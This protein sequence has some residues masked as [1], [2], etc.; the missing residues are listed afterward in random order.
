MTKPENH[1]IFLT[2]RVG[3]QLAK[4]VL[5][6]M[7][8]EGYQPHSSHMGLL[9]DLVE[10]DGQRQ[11]DLA[12]STIRNKGTVAR[13]LASLEA[14]GMIER[15]NDPKDRRQKRIFITE[16]GRQ[17]WSLAENRCF[18]ALDIAARGLSTEEMNNCTAVLHKIYLNLHLQLSTHE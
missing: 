7:K 8:Y 10:K 11:Q 16:K 14:G 12:I 13:A 9:A 2:N 3:R 1:L 18:G 5:T 4:L 17:L 15:K 6:N